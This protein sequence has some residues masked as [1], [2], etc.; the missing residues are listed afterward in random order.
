[1]AHGDVLAQTVDEVAGHVQ[2]VLLAERGAERDGFLQA[3]APAV[4]AVGLV[5]LVVVAVTRPAVVEAAATLALAAGL[6]AAS[7]VPLRTFLGRVAGPTAIAAFVVAPQAVLMAGPSLAGTPLS[8]TGVAYVALFTCRVAAAA[9]FVSLLLL[10]TRFSALLA[11][12][13]RLRVPST[14]VSLVAVTHRYLLVFFGELQRMVSARRMRTLRTPTVRETWRDSS[15]FL[16][17]FLIRTI[18][19]GERVERAARARG[20]GTAGYDRTTAL[21][22]ADGAFATLVVA[23]VVVVLA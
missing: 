11:G 9:A 5:A 17:T 14:A 15:N 16:G 2:W 21:G 3:V 23:V 7:R 4:K 10:T 1:M 18:E 13:R 20:G 6:A 22:V 19:R 8:V 12:V